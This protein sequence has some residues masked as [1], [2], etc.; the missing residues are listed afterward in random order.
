MKNTGRLQELK[1]RFKN[2][3]SGDI[4]HIGFEIGILLKGLNGVF[5]IVGGVLMLFMSPAR[6]QEIMVWLAQ[7]EW[8]EEPTDS[9]VKIIIGLS[10]NFSIDLQNFFILYLLSHGIAKSFI[11][12]ALL[13]RKLWAYPLSMML[14]IA[15]II[16]QIY[17]YTITPS[18]F[19]ILLTIFDILMIVL[20]YIEYTRVKKRQRSEI[21]FNET[22][23]EKR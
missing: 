13:K 16:Y 12:Y 9:I 22:T 15:F 18:V 3:L 23:D 6:V 11:V 19:L 10:Q 20:T 14:L 1:N 5:Q 17:K 21:K 4:Y 7:S 2:L 8:A